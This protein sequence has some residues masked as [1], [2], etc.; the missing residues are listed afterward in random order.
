[1]NT[2][3]NGLEHKDFLGVTQFIGEVTTKG[4]VATDNNEGG[5]EEAPPEEEQ[6]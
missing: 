5:E 4:S 2:I 1:M 6:Q 3:H